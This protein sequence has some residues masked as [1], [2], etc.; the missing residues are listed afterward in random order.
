M[1]A[2]AELIPNRSFPSLPR[3]RTVECMTNRETIERYVLALQQGD[4][5]AV[6]DSFAQHATWTLA[7]RLPLSGTWEGRDAI[8]NDFFGRARTLLEPGSVALEVT[9]LTAED[10]R[11]ALEW[12]SRARTADGEP[13]ENRCA[14]VF[15]LADGRITGVREYMDTDYALTAFTRSAG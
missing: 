1:P 2:R 10:D 12:T 9:S 14:G 6:A 4:Q 15:T 11:V 7:G 3:A 5:R 13:Y 8:M